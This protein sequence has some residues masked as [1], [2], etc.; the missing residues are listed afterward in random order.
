MH[1]VHWGPQRKKI[2]LGS[3]KGKNLGSKTIKTKDF[4]KQI[5]NKNRNSKTDCK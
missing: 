5:F 1:K 2:K 4:K 3:K